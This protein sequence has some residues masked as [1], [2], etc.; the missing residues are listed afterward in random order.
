[1]DKNIK[2]RPF[3]PEADMKTAKDG[4]IEVRWVPPVPHRQLADHLPTYETSENDDSLNEAQPSL[5]YRYADSHEGNTK[6]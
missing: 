3:L 4:Q 1:M 6:C 5:S 2:K